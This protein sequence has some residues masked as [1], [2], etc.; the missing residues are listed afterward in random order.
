[1]TAE[2]HALARQ[3]DDEAA[4][5]RSLGAALGDHEW[6]QEMCK[7]MAD[8]ASRHAAQLRAALDFH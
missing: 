8:A 2:L 4:A 7:A 1:M 3:W 5:H 6:M